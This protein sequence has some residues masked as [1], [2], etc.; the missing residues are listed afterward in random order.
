MFIPCKFLC[1]DFELLKWYSSKI[2]KKRQR[3]MFQVLVNEPVVE[4]DVWSPNYIRCD[5]KT[6]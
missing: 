3:D 2:Y 5:L 4:S 1:F 6:F